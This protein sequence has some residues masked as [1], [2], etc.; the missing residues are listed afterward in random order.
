MTEIRIRIEGGRRLQ[1]LLQNPEFVRGPLQLFLRA[2]SLEIEKE[3][4]LRT[5]VD[6]GRLRSSIKTSLAPLRVA[7][8]TN[9]HYA[10]HV[11]YG[12]RPHWPPLAAM[13]PWARRHGFPA[14]R[15]GAFLVA[16][17]ISQ[18][19]TRARRFMQRGAKAAIPAITRHLDQLAIAIEKRWSRGS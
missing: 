18:R 7:V 17:R 14:G 9:V 19:G 2:S 10:P 6:T 12:T 4:K 15:A 16:R 11:E 3:S 13:Q 1:K 5:P 8:G